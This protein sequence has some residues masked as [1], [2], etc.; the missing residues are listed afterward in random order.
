MNG[1]NFKSVDV[2]KRAGVEVNHK[3]LYLVDIGGI[4][5]ATHYTHHRDLVKL[6][7]VNLAQNGN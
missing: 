4:T 2:I 1:I 5:Y 3:G 7:G 6:L